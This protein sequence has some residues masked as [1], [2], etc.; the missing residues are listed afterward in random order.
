MLNVATLLA[1]KQ[2]ID[3]M[4]ACCGAFDNNYVVWW[5]KVVY[6]PSVAYSAEL[7]KPQK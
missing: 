1:K 7:S 2:L 4:T 3:S 6:W 5:E